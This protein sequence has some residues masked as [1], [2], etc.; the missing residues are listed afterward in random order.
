MNSLKSSK[1]LWRVS[2]RG[3]SQWRVRSLVPAHGSRPP[4]PS[5]RSTAPGRQPPAWA[6]SG[7]AS[8]GAARDAPRPGPSARR[9]ACPLGLAVMWSSRWQWKGRRRALNNMRFSSSVIIWFIHFSFWSS[10][11]KLMMYLSITGKEKETEEKVHC[12]PTSLGVHSWPWGGCCWPAGG[13]F[14]RSPPVPAPASG[15]SSPLQVHLARPAEQQGN[16]LVTLRL[17]QV[18]NSITGNNE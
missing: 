2:E 4:P 8:P 17:L 11:A 12:T 1:H 18:P 14:E 13:W 16:I 5:Q 3:N 15:A 10:L 7:A 6:A 9:T